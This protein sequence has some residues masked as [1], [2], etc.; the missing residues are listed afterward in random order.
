M[1]LY[2]S[3]YICLIMDFAVIIVLTLPVAMAL[4]HWRLVICVPRHRMC[5]YLIVLIILYLE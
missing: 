2:R 3:I 5:M 1:H 4:S